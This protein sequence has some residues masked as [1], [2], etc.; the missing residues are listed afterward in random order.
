MVGNQLSNFS[1]T[2][3]VPGKNVSS[4]VGVTDVTTATT[5]VDA[6][7]VTDRVPIDHN[8]NTTYSANPVED[9]SENVVV[10]KA[11]VVQQLASKWRL[12]YNATDA[13]KIDSLSR[14]NMF[15]AY[16]KMVDQT[17]GQIFQDYYT[18]NTNSH[19]VD[20][21]ECANNGTV[22][23]PREHLCVISNI[24][25]DDLDKCLAASG[26]DISH[27]YYVRTTEKSTTATTT[28]RTTINS[29]ATSTSGSVTQTKIKTSGAHD[30]TV[31]G[32]AIFLSIAG[33]LVLAVIAVIAFRKLRENRYRNQEFLLTD[34][35]FRYDGY[36]QLDDVN[37]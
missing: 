17:T 20:N 34:S 37:A 18:H 29:F 13:F 22:D 8:D 6:E 27:Y 26:N 24:L 15:K 9:R 36:S 28:R 23:C 25:K 19:I 10:P 21:D 31:K 14:E 12:S 32:V 35:V 5:V 30:G 3:A 4:D 11:V 1:A 7:T 33:V 2:A 16:K